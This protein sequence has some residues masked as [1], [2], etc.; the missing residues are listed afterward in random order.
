MIEM[1][2][3]EKLLVGI[4]EKL[5][6]VLKLLAV[7]TL[8]EIKTEQEKMELLDLIG[9]R[10]VEIARLLNKSPD[11]VSV[12]L[13]AI[14]KKRQAEKKPKAAEQGQPLKNDVE[15][16]GKSTQTEGGQNKRT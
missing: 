10:P 16:E 14:R 15:K 2:Q 1:S 9:F 7:N 6:K 4:T 8:K 12:Q 5:D 11:N 3:T 13:N